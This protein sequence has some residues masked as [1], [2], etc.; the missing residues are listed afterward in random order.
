VQAVAPDANVEPTRLER[1]L[2]HIR[3]IPTPSGIGRGIPAR[4][5]DYRF[6][7]IERYELAGTTGDIGALF[8][9]WA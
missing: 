7:H 4:P 8:V 6:N 3:C 1:Q 2:A 5:A 9:A